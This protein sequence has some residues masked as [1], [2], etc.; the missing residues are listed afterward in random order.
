MLTSAK[1]HIAD[2]EEQLE[3]DVVPTNRNVRR[4]RVRRMALNLLSPYISQPQ[5]KQS[6]IRMDLKQATTLVFGEDLDAR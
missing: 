3:G 6:A 4:R 1:S 5:T 2:G